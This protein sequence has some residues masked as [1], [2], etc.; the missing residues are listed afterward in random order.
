MFRIGSKCRESFLSFQGSLVLN[1][2]L[3]L[4]DR[5][6]SPSRKATGFHYFRRL[7]EAL[8]QHRVKHPYIYAVGLDHVCYNFS[9]F[10]RIARG[11]GFYRIEY[12][13]NER[14]WGHS[15]GLKALDKRLDVVAYL[16][17]QSNLGADRTDQPHTVALAAQYFLLY[18][19]GQLVP[20]LPYCRL[21]LSRR[22][23]LS[24]DSWLLRL[25]FLRSLALGFCVGCRGCGLSGWL[26]GWLRYFRSRFCGFC[27]LLIESLGYC[28]AQRRFS[29]RSFNCRS[30][31]FGIKEVSFVHDSIIRLSL[32]GSKW[33]SAII[34]DV[35]V[36]LLLGLHPPAGQP[37]SQTDQ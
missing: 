8:T 5:A 18:F 14:R 19:K 2:L 20:F 17:R 6:F 7:L 26:S 4:L 36:A 31:H 11:Q 28:I 1:R 10:L 24:W 32:G 25:F 3:M 9:L 22:L 27:F 33:I 23:Q 35:L 15:I 30:F 34:F 16:I 13:P 12:I 21:P 29:G 37:Q